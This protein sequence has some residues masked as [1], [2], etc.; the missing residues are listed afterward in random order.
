MDQKLRLGRVQTR[1]RPDISI[2]NRQISPPPV[3]FFRDIFPCAREAH[4]LSNRISQSTWVQSRAV[5]LLIFLLT[6][7]IW[8][9]PAE[10]RLNLPQVHQVVQLGDDAK[11]AAKDYFSRQLPQER[12][13]LPATLQA[14]LLGSLSENFTSACGTLLE[15]WAGE[16]GQ[17][18]SFW[19][20]RL[21]NHQGDRVWL[22]L[23]CGSRLQDMARYYDERLALLH[24]N[25]SSL[26]LLP[27]GPD[28][29]DD[30]GVYSLQFSKRLA[31]K[32]AEGFSFHVGISNNP[33]CD[34]PESRSQ[35]RLIVFADT[36]HGTFES[37]SV[38]TARDDSSHSDDPE[39]DIETT[40][41][42][43]VNFEHDSNS[44]ITAASAAF[45]ETVK[46]ITWES[47]KARAHTA[48]DRSGTLR[49][50]WNATTFRFIKI[51]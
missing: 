2:L 29:E 50:R 26:E 39:I 31:L 11:A 36:P 37:L 23:R 3:V 10:A 22:A 33:C 14:S 49:F 51:Q 45:R 44:F 1:W 4:Q 13:E 15:A 12:A 25:T 9:H 40:Y 32:N 16:R 7:C 47:G 8:T 48:S 6:C 27:L 30:E 21:L 19:R 34:G 38:I 20:V 41:R 17:S 35:E 24:L 28:T 42:A 43:R 5:A 18:S 46:D